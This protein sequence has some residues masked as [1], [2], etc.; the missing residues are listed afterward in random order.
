MADYA[1]L[2]LKDYDGERSSTRLN[3][4]EI[5]AANIDAT[6]TALGTLRTALEAIMLQGWY[7]VQMTDEIYTANPAVA[8]PFSQR[9]IKWQFI[10]EDSLG[11]VQKG[12]EIPCAD[13]SILEN[14]SKY[15]YKNKQVTVTTAA[16]LV[17]AVVDAFEAIAKDEAGNA[18]TVVDIYQAGRNI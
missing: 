11:N 7:G 4:A 8:D 15:I 14:G 5:T 13:L 10:V 12:N 18:L 17:Q 3:V 16:A 6:A 9:E 1:S 2:S